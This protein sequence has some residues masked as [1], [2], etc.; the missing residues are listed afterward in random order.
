MDP[1]GERPPGKEERGG[2]VR[3]RKIASC[4]KRPTVI[5]SK[6]RGGGAGQAAGGHEHRTR[7]E[8]EGKQNK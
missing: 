7:C 5:K 1:E 2:G 4:R 8:R 3:K 6:G